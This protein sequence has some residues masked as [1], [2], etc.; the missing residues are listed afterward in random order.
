MREKYELGSFLT[1]GSLKKLFVIIAVVLLSY[2][3]FA[4]RTDIDNE[5]E[6]PEIPQFFESNWLGIDNFIEIRAS[7]LPT[8]NLPT[9][10]KISSVISLKKMSMIQSNF[11]NTIIEMFSGIN[12]SAKQVNWVSTKVI[13][14]SIDYINEEKPNLVYHFLNFKFYQ[15]LIDSLQWL[16]VSISLIFI[17]RFLQK[18][19]KTQEITEDGLVVLSTVI[20][21]VAILGSFSC[22]IFG[23]GEDIQNMMKIK[24]APDMYLVEYIT[25]VA[26][27]NTNSQ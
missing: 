5:R 20:S 15:S 17:C 12:D 13:I 26:S 4:Q 16:G 24:Q 6:L 21:Y 7:N 10:Q 14:K 18:K 27:Q 19:I 3:V 11:N 8:M 25:H 1:V 23:G 9:N 2:S 22:M